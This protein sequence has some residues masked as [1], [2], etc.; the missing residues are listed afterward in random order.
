MVVQPPPKGGT[1]YAEQSEEQDALKFMLLGLSENQYPPHP[2]IIDC[3][4]GGLAEIKIGYLPTVARKRRC[5][6][7]PSVIY[8][9]VNKLL[10]LSVSLTTNGYLNPKP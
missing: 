9:I 7:P 4:G 10:S 5:I 2:M 3:T 1:L 8:L 6:Y